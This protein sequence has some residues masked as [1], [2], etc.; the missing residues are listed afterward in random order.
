MEWKRERERRGEEQKPALSTDSPALYHICSIRIPEHWASRSISGGCQ[1]WEMHLYKNH[2][3]LYPASC[4]F[5]VLQQSTQLHSSFKATFPLNKASYYHGIAF[6][7]PS[8]TFN[9]MNVDARGHGRIRYQTRW[10]T[11]FYRPAPFLSPMPDQKRQTRISLF[12][13]IFQ[14]NNQTSFLL[15]LLLVMAE[16]DLALLSPAFLSPLPRTTIVDISRCWRILDSD[17]CH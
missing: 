10:C 12:L 14:S 15:L 13:G 17:D 6:T 4:L 3:G 5:P 11:V 16:S 7:R 9:I 8:I 1:A 2:V